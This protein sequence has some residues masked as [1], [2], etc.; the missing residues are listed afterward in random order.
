[1]HLA[2]GH[3]AARNA[4]ASRWRGV[5]GGGGGGPQKSKGEG[6]QVEGE[7]ARGGEDKEGGGVGGG[8]GKERQGC[9]CHLVLFRNGQ[10]QILKSTLYCVFF[11]NVKPVVFFMS[12]VFFLMSAIWY[13]FAMGRRT[14]FKVLSIRGFR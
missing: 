10:V 3:M 6:L 12:V 2:D 1:M 13:C 11:L 7:G 8:G 14:F 9:V 4:A 5:W